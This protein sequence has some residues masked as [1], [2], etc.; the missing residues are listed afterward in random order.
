VL[1]AHVRVPGPVLTQLAFT[2]QLPFALAH[3]S[4]GVHT[5]PLPA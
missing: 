2:L 1:Q 4:T 5:I 3:A